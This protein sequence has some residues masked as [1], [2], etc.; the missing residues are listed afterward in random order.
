MRKEIGLLCGR[1]CS[2]SGWGGKGTYCKA[3]EKLGYNN[4]YPNCYIKRGGLTDVL[5]KATASAIFIGI[6]VVSVWMS[7]R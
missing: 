4:M 3:I 7:F 2:R 6:F 5:C 1:E